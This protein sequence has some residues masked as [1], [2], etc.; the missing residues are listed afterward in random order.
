MYIHAKICVYN[1]N[2]KNI[3]TF[4]LTYAHVLLSIIPLECTYVTTYIYNIY[5]PIQT[6]YARGNYSVIKIILRERIPK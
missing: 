5:T 3:N 4:T 6:Q 1:I 2:T